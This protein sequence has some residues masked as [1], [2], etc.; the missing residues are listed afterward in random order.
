[1]IA[2]GNLELDVGA[3]PLTESLLRLSPELFDDF[4]AVH[5]PSQLREDC[6]LIA[7]VPISRTVSSAL[8]SS[9]NKSF[10]NAT[11]NGC[12]IVLSKPIGSGM[13]A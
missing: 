1:M 9:N 4:D 3:A 8:I 7:E 12:E 2:I 10:I 11:I 6:G 13:L 5:F